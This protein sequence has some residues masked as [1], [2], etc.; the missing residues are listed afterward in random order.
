MPSLTK[1]ITVNGFVNL[2]EA[3]RTAG[4]PGGG[5][6]RMLIIDNPSTTVLVYV[7]FT[8]SNLSAGLTGTD[9]IALNSA[10]FPA[11]R[12][13][14]LAGGESGDLPDLMHTW[15]FTPSSIPITVAVFGN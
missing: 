6:P 13:L 15:L 10:A 11:E 14:V 9:G 12:R 5:R 4:F 2:G 7:H 3:L 1:P 8:N